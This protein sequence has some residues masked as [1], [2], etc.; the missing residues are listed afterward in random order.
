MIQNRILIDRNENTVWAG[1]SEKE[2][3]VLKFR[4]KRPILSKS[5]EQKDALNDNNTITDIVDQKGFLLL[6]TKNGLWLFDKENEIFSRPPCR[7]DACLSTVHVDI[8]KIFA[9]SNH[10]WLWVDQQLVKLNPGHTILHRFDLNTIQKQFDFE[11]KFID[12]RVM[13]ITE[14]NEGKFWIASQGLG[15]S[16]YD[17]ETNS[18]KNY[19]NDENDQNSI[20]SDVLNH[21]TIDRD[22]NVW[23]TTVNKGIVQL[24]KPSLVFY[25]Y[26]KGI[27]ST[28]VGIVRSGDASQIVVGTN[29]SGIW[30]SDYNGTDI[31]RLK[32]ERV[33][34][35][36]TVR[37][38]ENVVELS[39]GKKNIWIGTMQAGVAGLSLASDGKIDRNP[40]LFQHD[41]NNRN[42][43]SDNFIT[44]LWEDPEGHLWIGTFE[45]GLNL[46]DTRNYG[47]PGSVVNYH[48]DN[49]D[50]TSI[51]NNGITGFFSDDNG[52]MFIASFGGLDRVYDP[53]PPHKTFRFEHLITGAYCKVIHKTMDGT[54]YVLAEMDFM[55]VARVV[56]NIISKS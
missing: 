1:T 53:K 6:G 37:G 14:D 43:I 33:D 8:K 11:K 2:F 46:V 49:K 21:V 18:L 35:N 9:H 56:V 27:S 10:T 42:T 16:W 40:K 19:R 15:L 12:A 32:F 38:F 4:V 13:E 45:G 30:K 5:N 41:I 23:T 51:I 25:N 3:I 50:T 52:S 54:F 48:H 36:S 7:N 29:G 34:L 31:A 22:E 17:P 47:A 26:L 24:R 39:V 44:S 55:L 20:P 28:G